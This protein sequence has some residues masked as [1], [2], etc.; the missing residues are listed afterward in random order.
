MRT[1]ATIDGRQVRVPNAS[2]LGYDKWTAQVGDW[3]VWTYPDSQSD[4]IGRMTGRVHYAPACGESAPI[5]DWL[6]VLQLSD[7]H[8]H[9][10]IRWIDPQWVTRVHA[11]APDI[12]RFLSW[13]AGP[14]PSREWLNG[15]SEYGTLSAN[16][17]ADTPEWDFAVKRERYDDVHARVQAAGQPFFVNK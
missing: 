3:I 2:H 5:A 6:E 10:Y 17:R 15:A 4:L 1:D 13:F 16:H 8:T 14:L 7:D 11:N 12:Q 9:A